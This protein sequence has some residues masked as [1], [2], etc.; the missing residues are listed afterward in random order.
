MAPSMVN[1]YRAENAR[2]MAENAR[3]RARNGH[4][5]DAVEFV[6]AGVCSTGKDGCN[7]DSPDG[8]CE[9]CTCRTA[10]AAAAELEVTA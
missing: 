8:L 3:L 2:L 5:A 9:V 7:P 4:L 6:A 1:L 10:Q